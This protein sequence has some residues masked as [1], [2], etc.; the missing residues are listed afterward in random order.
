MG[1][2]GRDAQPPPGVTGL[3]SS[4]QVQEGQITHI[5]YEQGAPFLQ[6]SQVGPLGDQVEHGQGTSKATSHRSSPLQIQYVPVSPGQQLVT[7]AQ[8][9]AAAHSAVTGMGLD[10][11]DHGCPGPRPHFGGLRL[12][13]LSPPPAAVAD[14][15]MAQAQGLFGTEEAV[16][17]H[18]Q[19]LQH[20]G[21]EYDVITL[22]DD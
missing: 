10:P 7:Q 11:A 22:T 15:A 19:Q 4:L 16:P 1:S 6:E 21:I 3:P 17:E 12:T 8:L 13:I 5:Q 18:I 9:E 2:G 20:Q 14:A